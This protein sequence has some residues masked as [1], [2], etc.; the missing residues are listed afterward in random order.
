MTVETLLSIAAL[1]FGSGTATA[2]AWWVI[3]GVF[4]L[5][6]RQTQIEGEIALVKA[7]VSR[8]HQTCH[9]RE[10]WLKENTALL[11][12]INNRQAA[13]AAKLGVDAE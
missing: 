8:I 1:L 12:E 13:M 3:S 2:A 9:G 4:G 11:H 6:N 7:E 10:M 5:K